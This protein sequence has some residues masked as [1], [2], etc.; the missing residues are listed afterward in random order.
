MYIFVGNLPRT[1]SE[2]EL[3]RMVER[4]L[5]PKGFKESARQV[6][7]KSDQVKRS[8]F[9][10]FDKISDTGIVRHGQVL[11]EPEAM[12]KR[13]LQRLDK[14]DCRGHQLCVREFTIRAYHNDRRGLDWRKKDWS[15]MERR[16]IERRQPTIEK[17]PN[18]DFFA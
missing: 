12:A 6:L 16:L 17:E 3:R 2:F 4:M 14:T 18:K 13:L 7:F 1:F 8:E 9:C 11:I 10:V 15:G 5:S